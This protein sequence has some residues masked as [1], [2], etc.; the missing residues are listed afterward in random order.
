MSL[1]GL[2]ESEQCAVGVGDVGREP[3]CGDLADI[4]AVLATCGLNRLD[5]GMDVVDLEP[6]DHR[7]PLV[8][9]AHDRAVDSVPVTGVLKVVSR[10][11]RRCLAVPSESVRVELR[12][13]FHSLGC[14]LKVNDASHTAE[15]R[16]K[17]SSAA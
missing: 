5:A 11:E 3:L 15:R 16:E 6:E 17:A 12:R 13:G 4:A 7:L 14:D 1:E 2:S 10:E 8:L 9:P